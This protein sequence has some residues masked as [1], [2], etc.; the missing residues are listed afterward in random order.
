MRG[1]TAKPLELSTY[2]LRDLLLLEGRSC[3]RVA[4]VGI[5]SGTCAP[6]PVHCSKDTQ[7]TAVANKVQMFR[8]HSRPWGPCASVCAISY[9]PELPPVGPTNPRANPVTDPVGS[10]R[11]RTPRSWVKGTARTYTYG[12]TPNKNIPGDSCCCCRTFVDIRKK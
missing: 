7:R 5:S 12:G 10:R 2:C 1:F 6:Q 11:K 9:Q 8:T 4:P 3:T